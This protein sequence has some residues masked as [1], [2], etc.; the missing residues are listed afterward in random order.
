MMVEIQSV[1]DRMLAWELVDLPINMYVTLGK[2]FP[3]LV[4]YF[5]PNV[6]NSYDAL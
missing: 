2:I 6:R 3:F 1:E 4:V 5:S